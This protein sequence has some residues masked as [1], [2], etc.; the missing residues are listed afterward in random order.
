MSLLLL[1]GT[2]D[3]RRIASRL[4]DDGVQLVYSVAGLV[5][6]PNVSC[7]VISG[8]F[9]QYGGLECY[10]AQQKITA[11]LDV[12]HPYAVQMSTTA[13]TSARQCRIPYW[14]FHRQKWTQ[15]NQ[16]TWRHFSSWQTLMASLEQ[17]KRLFLTVGQISQTDID[18][19]SKDRELVVLRTAVQPKIS[20]PDNVVWL[21]AI[22]PFNDEGENQLMKQ[23]CF[24]ALVSKNSGGESTEA[25]LRAAERYQVT[26][27]MLDR[28]LLPNADL[29]FT[30][31]AHCVDY[32]LSH[33][34]SS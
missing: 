16:S 1:G 10:I 4:H 26:V 30:S 24:D 23:Y 17:R 12:T 25:K 21:R 28:P 2:A 5:R 22:G 13:A 8:G 14:R 15:K 20:L 27:Y 34:R 32:I 31:D 11:I 19:L 3:G 29:E 9:R 33:Y 18:R 6:R 7:E